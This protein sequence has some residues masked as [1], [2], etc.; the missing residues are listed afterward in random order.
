MIKLVFVISLFI[1]WFLNW[2]KL[3]YNRIRFKCFLSFILRSAVWKFIYLK[4]FPTWKPSIMRNIICCTAKHR[5]RQVA[6]KW[7]SFPYC[8][9]C[10]FTGDTETVKPSSEISN[11]NSLHIFAENLNFCFNM[12]FK[13]KEHQRVNLWFK[14]KTIPNC[15]FLLELRNADSYLTI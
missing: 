4:T 11:E 13:S 6:A 2:N 9:Y 5:E 12:V 3:N 1:N 8:N 10:A 14:G 15:C 7:I